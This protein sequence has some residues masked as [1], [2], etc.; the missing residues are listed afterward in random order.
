[1]RKT[2]QRKD[3]DHFHMHLFYYNLPNCRLQLCTTTMTDWKKKISNVLAKL[4]TAQVT[5]RPSTWN[6]LLIERE[7]FTR[8][9]SFNLP[10]KNSPYKS[11][12]PGKNSP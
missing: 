12:L 1:M 4:E 2:T 11:K 8:S 5:C 9:K 3:K 7:F 6:L 10:P